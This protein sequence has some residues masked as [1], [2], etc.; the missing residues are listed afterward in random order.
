MPALAE[1]RA[2]QYGKRN[3]PTYPTRVFYRQEAEAMN[4]ARVAI[5]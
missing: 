1:R 5:R 3:V 2:S 4:G